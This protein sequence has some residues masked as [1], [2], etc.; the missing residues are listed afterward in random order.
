MKYLF[1]ASISLLLAACTVEPFGQPAQSSDPHVMVAV[2]SGYLTSTAQAG[3]EQS[4]QATQQ[5]AREERLSE[6]EVAAIMAPVTA[7]AAML[8]LHITAGAA[9]DTAA[10]ATSTAGAALATAAAHASQ[11][12]ETRE[13]NVRKQARTDAIA[14]GWAWFWGILILGTLVAVISISY[15]FIKKWEDAAIEHR[16]I[17][18]EIE[19][20]KRAIVPIPGGYIYLGPHGPEFF[21]PG[22]P[23]PSP[24]IGALDESWYKEQPEDGEDPTPDQDTLR[25]LNVAHQKFGPSSD[26]LPGW[27]LMGWTPSRWQRVID[28]WRAQGIIDTERGHKTFLAQQGPYANIHELYM[29]L[30]AGKLPATNG[31]GPH[32]STLGSPPYSVAGD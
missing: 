12:T 25:L 28:P 20:Q 10:R 1:Y 3:N 4:A 19:R 30:Q 32:P 23:P 17:E 5:A 8:D 18:L 11:A 24:G 15:R 27:R 21:Q 2:G 22:K 31:L 16:R 26:R 14:L 9:T 6:L 29:D 13:A 7:Q